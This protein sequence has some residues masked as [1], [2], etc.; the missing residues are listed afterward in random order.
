[1][2]TENQVVN[3]EIR[4]FKE[5]LDKILLNILSVHESTQKVAI[6]FFCE[7]ARRNDLKVCDLLRNLPKQKYMRQNRP[8]DMKWSQYLFEQ[9]IQQ[10]VREIFDMYKGGYGNI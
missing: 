5:T 6:H 2:Q 1:M 9:E 10:K 8:F 3:D 4:F 7:V